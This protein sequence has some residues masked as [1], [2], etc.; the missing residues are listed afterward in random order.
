MLIQGKSSS[1]SQEASSALLESDMDDS[2]SGTPTPRS[3]TSSTSSAL[4]PAT[5]SSSL[6]SGF[7]SSLRSKMGGL[8]PQPPP[9]KTGGAEDPLS[10][11]TEEAMAG[12]R[13]K[14]GLGEEGVG[15][16]DELVLV[17]HGEP[18]PLFFFFFIPFRSGAMVACQS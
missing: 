11:S 7:L 9:P 4:K 15:E 16:V 17:V 14:E 5:S 12:P 10:N 8:A 18:P 13:K 1:R 3:R 6:G 2:P